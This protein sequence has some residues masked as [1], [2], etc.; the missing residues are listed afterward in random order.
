MSVTPSATASAV[1][2]NRSLRANSPR[3]ATLRM[4]LAD[5]LHEVEDV[6]GAVRLLG[7]VDDLAVGEDEQPVG[8]GGGGRVV[9]DHDDRLAELVDGAAQ[10]VEDLAG[11]L[12]VEVAGRL[13][14]EDDGGLARQRT[15]DGDA[16]LLA[17]RE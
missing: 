4:E 5:G 7:V 2:I 16:L 8:V 12:G 10:Q 9:R 3:R 15:G 11:G 13:V 6:L 14:G 17:A 1:R